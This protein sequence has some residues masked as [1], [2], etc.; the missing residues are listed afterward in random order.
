MRLREPISLT[1]KAS[2][3]V[4]FSLEDVDQQV[5]APDFGTALNHDH[6]GVFRAGPDLATTLPWGAVAST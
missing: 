3:Y 4:N 6:Y 1:R 2:L 5:A